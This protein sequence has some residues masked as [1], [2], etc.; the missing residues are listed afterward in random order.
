VALTAALGEVSMGAAAFGLSLC[1][2]GVLAGYLL[3]TGVQMW[4]LEGISS[5]QEL[6]DSFVGAL[7]WWALIGGFLVVAVIV[8]AAVM[9]RR[10]SHE[11]SPVE[12]GETSPAKPDVVGVGMPEVVPGMPDV[13][14]MREVVPGMPDV[15]GTSDVTGMPPG[16]PGG[17]GGPAPQGK[18]GPPGSSEPCAP[19]P[20]D[21]GD[22]DDAGDS[23]GAD[24]A[25]V[26]VPAVPPQAPSPED[27]GSS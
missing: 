1:F 7:H 6:V 23:A 8:L 19:E 20:G 9:A 16:E 24:A 22:S 27:G 17:G 11:E 4:M 26:P 13:A 10:T 12:S 15:P 5:R 2:A 14:G 3:G 25:G 21:P 18:S